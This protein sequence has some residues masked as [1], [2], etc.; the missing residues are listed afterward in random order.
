MPDLDICR[1][2]ILSEDY[3]DFILSG[4]R[5]FWEQIVQEGVCQI[6]LEYTFRIVTLA[7]EG[8]NSRAL[9][10]YPYF[11]V[12]KCYTLLDMEALEQAGVTQVQGLPGLELDG[13]GVLIGF[14]DT[15]IRYED[16]VFRNLDGST[17]ILA[18]WDQTIQ[19]GNSPENFPYG[20][21]YTREQIDEAIKS[22][23][24]QKI[25]PSQDT[26]GHG[27]FIASVACG[28]GNAENQF[29]GAAPEAEIAVVKLKEAKQYLRNF[30]F[31]APDAPCYQETDI[32]AGIYYLRMLALRENKPLILCIALGTNLGGHSGA[33]PL[34]SYLEVLSSTSFTAIVVGGGNEADKRHHF[35]GKV[36][37]NQ[38]E[39][40]E[41]SVGADVPGFVMEIWTEIPNVLSVTVISPTGDQSGVI[42]VRSGVESYDFIF[43]KTRLNVSYRLLAE[44]TNSELIFFQFEKPLTGIWRIR[45]EAVQVGDGSYHSWLPVDEFIDG[46]V[47]FLR[48]N[49]DY[50]ITSPG[51][52]VSNA[53]V[54]YYNGADNSVAVS[55][56]RGYTRLERVKPDFAAPG[57]RVTGV[58]LRGQFS[59]R[60]GS[61]V[62]A[63]IT[64][65]A[66]AL[67]ME[68]L[69]RIGEIPDSMQIRN[70]LILGA[71]R[72]DGRI[73][74]NREWGYGTLNLYHTFEQIRRF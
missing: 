59:V 29:L 4:R 57:I 26:N 11:S 74:P 41:V 64:A 62:A 65:G 2:Q 37:N 38:E 49:P 32:M 43:E 72:A 1:Q 51:D 23:F 47:F 44:N 10:Q 36:Q 50:T 40:I 54:A 18:I 45:I 70:L 31:I 68:W 71:T 61:S 73:Y 48:S 25:V 21:E 5:G 12:P 3:M 33:T 52:S 58:N 35:L 66:A 63:G 24:P 6:P 53:T 27:T 22:G 8:T 67:L 46:E 55:S 19:N 20:S 56:G 30:Y 9:Y 42:P 69:V 28:S 14:I 15:G 39:E 16:M 17:R 13:K 60:S 34:A 7:K